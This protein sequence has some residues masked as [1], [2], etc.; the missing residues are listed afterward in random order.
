MVATYE[1]ISK[2]QSRSSRNKKESDP[3]G[4]ALVKQYCKDIDEWPD[5]W[6]ISDSDIRIGKAILEQFKLLLADRIQKGRAKTTINR[7][8]GYLAALGGELISRINYDDCLRKLSARKLI[9][10]YVDE[11][12]GPLWRHAYDELDHSRYDSV[13]R[14]LYKVIVKLE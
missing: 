4:T 8:A 10:E 6:A 3:T 14:A 1:N 2:Q 5:N 9:L 13:C 7:Y 12:G 11:N